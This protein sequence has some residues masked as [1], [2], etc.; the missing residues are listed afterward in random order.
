MDVSKSTYYCF[1]LLLVLLMFRCL[2]LDEVKKKLIKVRKHQPK[3][4]YHSNYFLL[5]TKT[6]TSKK[7][8]YITASLHHPH[9][10]IVLISIIKINECNF[11]FFR[12]L[13]FP[14]LQQNMTKHIIYSVIIML[15]QSCNAC[16]Y[17][18][19]YEQRLFSNTL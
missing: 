14:S 17:N 5:K 4:Y 1:Y 11:Q 15:F 3:F 19:R 12:Q 16:N 18:V 9:H 10:L 2:G 13:R 8:F 6:N 7:T